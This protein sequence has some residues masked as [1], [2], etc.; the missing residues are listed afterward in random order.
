VHP[1]TSIDSARLEQLAAADITHG[2][3]D[4][5]DAVLERDAARALTLAEQLTENDPPGRLVY[6][7][8]RRLREVLRAAEL[9]DAGMPQAKLA[10][11]MGMPAWMVKKVVPAAKRADRDALERAICLFADFELNTRGGELDERTAFSL[12]LARASR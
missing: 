5:A 11:A 10:Q 2:A 1:D 3:Y 12:T 7:I 4:V 8:V 6:P 9:M